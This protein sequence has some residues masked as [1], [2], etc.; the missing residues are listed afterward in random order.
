MESFLS[1]LAPCINNYDVGEDEN[2]EWPNNMISRLALISE[3]GLIIRRGDLHKKPI[4]LEEVA[5][6]RRIANEAK[7]VAGELEVGMGSESGD[8]FQ[9]F[10]LVATQSEMVA[11][12][13]DETLIRSR[14]GD[15]LFPPV[16]MTIEPLNESG[17][18]WQ[19][20]VGW[21]NEED[22]DED[23]RSEYVKPWR[24]L[25]AWFKECPDFT[26]TAFV[27]IG[28]RNAL[29]KIEGDSQVTPAGTELTPSCL[30]R[31]AVGL[32]HKGSLC[33]LFGISVQT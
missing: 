4:S 1:I 9:P 20:V 8:A 17:V 11:I 32:T 19:D 22:L 31:M 16:S 10:W 27:R 14:F 24:A 7:E 2:A 28:D 6:C 12:S 3:D 15:T 26:Q 5:H 18:W 33:G 25:L 29:W 13:I 23:E 30:P 21:F